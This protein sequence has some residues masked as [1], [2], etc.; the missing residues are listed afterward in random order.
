MD[1]SL[2]TLLWHSSVDA[3]REFFVK[4]IVQA[5]DALNARFT[6]VN[7]SFLFFFLIGEGV[8]KW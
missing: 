7:P 2:L 5:M 4:V 8:V 6:K 3:L 1:R